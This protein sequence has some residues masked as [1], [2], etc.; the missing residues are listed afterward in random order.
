MLM[1]AIM[2]FNG[3]PERKNFQIAAERTENTTMRLKTQVVILLT[4]VVV[5]AGTH[6]WAHHSLTASWDSHH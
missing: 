2:D 6:A 4:A 1:I 3:A 5:A